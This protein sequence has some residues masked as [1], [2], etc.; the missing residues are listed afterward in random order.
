MNRITLAFATLLAFT[1][2]VGCASVQTSTAPPPAAPGHEVAVEGGK[3]TELTV[4]EFRGMMNQPD[5][6]VVNVHVPFEG[7]LPNTDASIAFDHIQE[8]LDQLPADRNAKILLYCRSGRM[9]TTA[10][11]T[12]A[13]LGYTRVYNLTGGFNAWKAAGYTMAAK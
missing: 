7:D 4:P 12:L 6:F 8:H 11:T 3:Y 5:A 10:A 13:K 9:G 2:P 1:F